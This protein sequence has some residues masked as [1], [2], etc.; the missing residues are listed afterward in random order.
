MVPF[1]FLK[2]GYEEAGNRKY[3]RVLP[4]CAN[5]PQF[6]SQNPEEI[7]GTKDKKL[8]SPIFSIFYIRLLCVVFLAM[9]VKV[10]L[11]VL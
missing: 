1:S 3:Q 11:A 7:Q 9:S 4:G 6:Q 2:T 5:Q 8:D 10:M